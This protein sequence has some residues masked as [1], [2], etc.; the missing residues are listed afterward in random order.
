MSSAKERRAQ[1][2]GKST[3]CCSLWCSTFGF[4]I[5][6]SVLNLAPFILAAVSI[7]ILDSADLI[8]QDPYNESWCNVYDTDDPYEWYY[9]D[10]TYPG[11]CDT[12]MA[13]FAMMLV[14]SLSYVNIYF[15]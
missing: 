6:W 11:Q 5:A 13:Q 15:S 8:I 3:S 14:F 1:L 12:L 4:T 9:W 7:S 2:L 10:Y